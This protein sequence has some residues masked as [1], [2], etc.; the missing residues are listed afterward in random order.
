VRAQG[1]PASGAAETGEGVA[2]DDGRERLGVS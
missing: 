2:Q 1:A